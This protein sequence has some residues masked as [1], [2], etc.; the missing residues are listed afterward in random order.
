M[1]VIEADQGV[2]LLGGRM[3][4]NGP[5]FERFSEALLVMNAWIQMDQEAGRSVKVA[6]VEAFEGMVSVLERQTR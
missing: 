3:V 5:V 6:R 1:P 2:Y 4:V